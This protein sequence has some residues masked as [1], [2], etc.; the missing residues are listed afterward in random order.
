MKLTRRLDRTFPGRRIARVPAWNV[1]RVSNETVAPVFGAIVC[2]DTQGV[3]AW[4]RRCCA[5]GMEETCGSAPE[6]TIIWLM[7]PQRALSLS[8]PLVCVRHQNAPEFLLVASYAGDFV[9]LGHVYSAS[10]E[11]LLELKV[12]N[13]R[14]VPPPPPWVAFPKK[15]PMSTWNQGSDGYF[16][17][18]IWY[19]YLQALTEGERIA[20]LKTHPAPAS[21]IGTPVWRSASGHKEE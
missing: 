1:Q 13:T 20:L 4:P 18:E 16:L 21:W 6:D 7:K 14:S 11:F 9:A 17:G 19:P 3:M 12:L 5:C 2:L 15:D 8:P 10:E